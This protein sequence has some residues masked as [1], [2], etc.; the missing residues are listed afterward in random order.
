MVIG[1]NQSIRVCRS[2][3]GTGTIIVPIYHRQSFNIGRGYIDERCDTCDS[4]DGSGEVED[5]VASIRDVY[6]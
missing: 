1:R 6:S 2:C 5:D 3:G 4:C